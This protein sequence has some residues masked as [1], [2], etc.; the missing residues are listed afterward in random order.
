MGLGAWAQPE[1]GRGAGLPRT[2]S[3][4]GV[5]VCL[6]HSLSGAALRV[7]SRPQGGGA[8]LTGRGAK[9]LDPLPSQE[10]R[11]PALMAGALL[12]LEGWDQDPRG[13]RCPGGTNT[14]EEVGGAV[15][16]EV[17]GEVL[18][19]WDRGRNRE[20]GGETPGVGAGRCHCRDI[21]SGLGL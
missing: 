4:K 10:Q 9:L 2:P 6:P 13:A 11:T 7:G 8:E 15:R 3:P 16:M 21:T 5:L 12:G 20:I 14:A 17:C 19:G 18:K 1:A